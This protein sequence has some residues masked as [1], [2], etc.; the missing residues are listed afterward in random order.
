ML[1]NNHTQ[2]SLSFFYHFLRRRSLLRFMIQ[3]FFKFNLLTRFCLTTLLTCMFVLPWQTLARGQISL[4]TN[5]TS[6]SLP[7]SEVIRYGNLEVTWVKSPIDNQELFQIAAPTVIDRHNIEASR[8]PV[9]IRATNI[10]ALLRLTVSR[11]R[12]DIVT[13]IFSPEL[14]KKTIPTS[15][16]VITSTL[17]NRPVVQIQ[18][19]NN[20]RPLTIAT[21]TQTDVEFYSQTSEQ[22]VRDWQKSIQ[23]KISRIEYLYSSEVIRDRLGQAILIVIVVLVISGILGL[24][25]WWLGRRLSKLQLE[26]EAGISASK[27]ATAKMQ[28]EMQEDSNPRIEPLVTDTGEINDPNIFEQQAYL[29]RRLDSCQS[30]RWLLVWL[31][32]ALWYLSVY[33]ITTR[34]PILMRWSEAVV[35]QPLQLLAIWFL[36]SLLLEITKTFIHRSIDAWKAN[37]YL[38]FGESQRKSLR[39]TT[40][41][42]ALKGF[43]IFVFI[44]LGIILTLALF[45]ISTGSILAGSAVI[46]LAI[47]FG[48]QNLVKDVV[49]GCLILLEDRFAVGDVI[50]INNM[51]GFVEGF[52]LRITQL[53]DPEGQLITIPNSAIAEVRNLTRL[54]SRVDFTIEVAYENEPDKVL[55]VL[56]EVGQEMYHS[57]D[58]QDK[59]P[60]PP[61]ILGIDRLSHTGMLV[62]V[63]IVT[64]PL[65]QWVVGREYRL[66]VRR[67]FGQYNIIIGRPE[68]V[69]YTKSDS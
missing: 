40:I 46:G 28:S 68:W 66:R 57:P 61:E 9:E 8:L 27:S 37:P 3:M 62:R 69:S 33:A 15:A 50:A 16:K 54:W 53:R 35:S 1:E 63:W 55:Q 13:K 21:V 34:L 20:S 19:S 4:H 24:I 10:E 39:L 7:P 29:Q 30:L 48:M 32:I 38:T 56:K 5:N 47:S 49:N 67:A 60:E 12:G 6:S 58:W 36:I 25:H 17:N 14:A 23:Q 22:I 64:A 44:S 41:A 51:S 18:I 45:N 43:T 52:N 42:T 65:Q 31:V 11:I 59:L 2:I 26:Y